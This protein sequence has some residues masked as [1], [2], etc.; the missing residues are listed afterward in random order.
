MASAADATVEDA[1]VSRDNGIVDLVVDVGCVMESMVV[2]V[3]CVVESMVVDVIE[4][5]SVDSGVEVVA[6]EMLDEVVKVGEE[7]LDDDFVGEIVVV[8]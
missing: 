5:L 8:L 4:E 3:G 6:V 7:G 2:D 1:A